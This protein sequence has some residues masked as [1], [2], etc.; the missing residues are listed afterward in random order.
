[1]ESE[2]QKWLDEIEKSAVGPIDRQ[3]VRQILTEALSHGWSCALDSDLFDEVE[4]FIT[5]EN[6]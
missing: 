2:M 5:S 4:E 3:Y 6:D 1:M